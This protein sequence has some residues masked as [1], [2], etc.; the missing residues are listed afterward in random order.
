MFCKRFEY[1]PVT[2]I[3][4]R[5]RAPGLRSFR[6]GH[7]LV[8]K[9]IVLDLCERAVISVLF[10]NFVYRMIP[11]SSGTI[12]IITVLLVLSETLPF[13]Y[14]VLRTPSI[15]LS[16]RPSDWIFAILGTTMPLMV[17]P[18]IN[19][20]PLLP[21]VVCSSV[22]AA[23]L[24]LQISAKLV[25]GRAF[26]IVAANRSIKILGP[27]RILRHPMYAGYSL[28]HVGFLIAAPS[29]TNSLIYATA[30]LV[31]ILRMFREERLLMQDSGYRV[32]AARVRYRLLPGLF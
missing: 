9:A 24:S 26:G 14:I 27:Y 12:N 22:M 4:H 8:P 19:A 23:G 29:L 15:T 25:L 10:F 5:Q 17:Q 1:Y 16:Q 7:R 21:L 31:Q 11:G 3:V 18:Q 30:L 20:A 32:F 2:R 28:T 13:V 6:L